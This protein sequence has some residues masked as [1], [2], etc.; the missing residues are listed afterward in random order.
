M[1]LTLGLFKKLEKWI[2]NLNQDKEKRSCKKEKYVCIQAKL[3]FE[4]FYALLL[5]FSV[6][7]VADVVSN[8]RHNKKYC[9]EDSL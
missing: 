9:K 5:R 4:V 8:G 3:F 1:I 2:K 6:I 7:D